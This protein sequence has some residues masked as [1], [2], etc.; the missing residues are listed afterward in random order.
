MR[1]LV[2][3]GVRV[4]PALL[5]VAVALGLA[6]LLAAMG[7]HAPGRAVGA[8]VDGSLGSAENVA[9]VLVR[10]TPLV[11]TGVAVMLAFRSGIFNIGAEGQF[12]VGALAAGVV[13]TRWGSF[14]GQAV[15]ALLAGMLAGAAWA[16]LPALLRIRRGVSEVI[17][18]ILL[19]FVALY[20]VS[21]A[22]NG[23]LQEASRTYPQSDA[24]AATSELWQLAPSIDD[25]LHAGVVLALLLAVA[26]GA[27]ISRTGLGLRLRAAGLNADAA[28]MAGFPVIR[29]LALAFALSGA[30]AGLGGAVELGGVTHRLFEKISPGYGYTA[31]AVALL[32]G[33]RVPGLVAAALF[34]AALGA[35]ATA[36]ER[37]VGVS[38]VL[39]V[40]VQGA[41]LLAVA[42]LG[43]PAVARWIE[44]RTGRRAGAEAS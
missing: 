5:A 8:L 35:G 43:T 26:A 4:L 34:F 6:A 39:A 10:A 42:T 18:T 32:G 31:I 40:A 9:D 11:F 41:T 2:D 24:L 25:R 15:A 12:L 3:L 37:S 33:L 20:L 22:V 19:N 1:R 27:L 29:D 36:M 16:S 28:R 44:R 14:P 17:T 13:G 30:I 21:W 23:P 38:A 7:G